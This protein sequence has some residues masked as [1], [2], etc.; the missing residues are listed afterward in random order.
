MAGGQSSELRVSMGRFFEQKAKMF[1]Q[2]NE[3]LK[4]YYLD[5]NSHLCQGKNSYPGQGKKSG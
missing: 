1:L 5:L 2:Q 4:D 3:N